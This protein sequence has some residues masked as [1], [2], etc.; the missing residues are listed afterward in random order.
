M[1]A[2]SDVACVDILSNQDRSKARHG[3][4]PRELQVLHLVA[5]GQ[6][7]QAIAAML[8]LGERTVDRHVSNIFTKLDVTTRTAAG[9]GSLTG[10]TAGCEGS[11]DGSVAGH[12]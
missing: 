10:R 5:S 4:T 7:N 1:G 12:A 2:A 6:V 9:S 11:G 3:L 8:H